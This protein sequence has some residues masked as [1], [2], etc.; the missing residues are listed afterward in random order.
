MAQ[1]A[2]F[3]VMPATPRQASWAEA[4]SLVPGKRPGSGKKTGKRPWQ[5]QQCLLAAA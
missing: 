5:L 3:A 1:C 2:V 4:N